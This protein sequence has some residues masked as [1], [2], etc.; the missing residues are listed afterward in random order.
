LQHRLFLADEAAALMAFEWVV[1]RSL[2]R[3]APLLWQAKG[4]PW[5]WQAVQERF[6]DC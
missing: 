3:L 5:L 2:L 4:F 6:Q 1:P